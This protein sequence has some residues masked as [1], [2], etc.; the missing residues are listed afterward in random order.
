M[1]WTGRAASCGCRPTDDVELL[2]ICQSQQPRLRHF[3]AVTVVIAVG[4]AAVSIC[5]TQ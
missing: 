2:I 3:D 1:K 5:N 4:P